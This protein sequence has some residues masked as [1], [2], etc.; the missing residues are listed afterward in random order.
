MS[1]ILRVRLI[2]LLSRW[3]EIRIHLLSF[4]PRPVATKQDVRDGR[5][6]PWCGQHRGI[7]VMHLSQQSKVYMRVTLQTH[8]YWLSALLFTDIDLV[9]L[10]S[11]SEGITKINWVVFPLNL[12]CV[13]SLSTGGLLNKS[14]SCQLH[15]CGKQIHKFFSAV[16]LSETVSYCLSDSWSKLILELSQL[17]HLNEVTGSWTHLFN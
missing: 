3:H 10:V 6:L 17:V 4:T 15:I 16:L 2:G 13:F 1:T 11:E 12:G 14:V 8:R 5:V 7:T 9:V